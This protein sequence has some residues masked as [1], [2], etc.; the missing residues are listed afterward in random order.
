MKEETKLAVSESKIKTVKESI[1][2]MRNYAMQYAYEAVVLDMDPRSKSGSEEK[3]R[4]FAA[5]AG[6]MAAALRVLGLD[7]DI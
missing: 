6:G 7:K 2:A 3:A 5:K 4:I 1:Q